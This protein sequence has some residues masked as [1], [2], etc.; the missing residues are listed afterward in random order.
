LQRSFLASTGA[1]LLVLWI[2]SSARADELRFG[3]INPSFGGNPLNSSHLLGTAQAQNTYKED[4]NLGRFR[5]DLAA[6]LN[7]PE[8]R[9]VGNTLVR[10][11]V[12][13][14]GATVIDIVDLETN[15]VTQ[16]VLP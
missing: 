6:S 14:D 13:D 10:T 9:I 3:F 8:T 1:I 11:S 16:I 15:E 5:A 4:L 7:R 2:A 12:N